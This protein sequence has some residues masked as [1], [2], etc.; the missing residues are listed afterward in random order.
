M[1]KYYL[2]VFVLF[3]ISACSETSRLNVA[4]ELAGDNRNELEKVLD[5]YSKSPEDSLKL[6]AAIFLIENMPYHY[7]YDGED[8]VKYY[9]KID[10][11]SHL[12]KNKLNPFPQ[13]D[14]LNGCKFLKSVTNVSIKADI[15]T[16]TATYLISHIDKA[17]ETREYPWNKDVLFS[18]FCEYVLPYRI[19]NE[20]LE[21]WIPAYKS[22]LSVA[23]DSLKRMN[24]TTATIV[25]GQYLL[26]YMKD[27]TFIQPGKQEFQFMLDLY[28]TTFLNLNVATCKELTAKGTYAMKTLG[29]PIAWDYTPHWGNRSKGHDWNLL[30]NDKDTVL[31]TFQIDDRVAFGSHLRLRKTNDRFAKIYRKTYSIQDDALIMQDMDEEIPPSFKNPHIKDV[32]SL[33]LETVD[34]NIELTASPP[35]PKKIAYIMVFDNREWV[36]VHWGKIADNKARFREMG[37]ACA[38]MVMYYHKGA[39]IPASNAFIVDETGEVKPLL[40]NTSSVTSATLKRKYPLTEKR[41]ADTAK[42]LLGGIFQGA[43]RPD[44]SDSI[45]LHKIEINCEMLPHY[46]KLDKPVSCKYFRYISAPKGYISMAEIGVYD[47]NGEKLHGTVTGTEGSLNNRRGCDRN[48]AFDGDVL[49]F[50][51]APKH[52]GCWVGLAFEKKEQLA[53]IM[54]LP[55]NDDNFIQENENY[56]LLFWDMQWRSLGRKTGDKTHQLV[57]DNVPENTLLLLRNHTKG[58]EERIFTY[59]DGEQVWW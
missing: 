5:H 4:L 6:R 53:E 3:L 11:I 24:D 16:I 31:N 58:K 39:F 21:D 55:W 18:D 46:V 2:I 45:L 32:T 10:S 27:S 37:K 35:S 56:E 50:F 41:R 40:P 1:K 8:A 13:I 51:D 30:I 48:A 14:A 22:Y 25:K 28:P 29:I 42:R 57:Y 43:N 52:T 38:Y 7:S 47:G 23:I 33:Y 26:D 36:P 20:P 44:F 19:L 49:T 12:E 54:F 15:K 59:E 17:F 34:I 9:N